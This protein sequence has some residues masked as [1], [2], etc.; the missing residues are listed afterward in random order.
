M[1]TACSNLCCHFVFTFVLYVVVVLCVVCCVFVVCVVFKCVW[2][3]VMLCMLLDV[4]SLFF[5]DWCVMLF[6]V[7]VLLRL[8]VVG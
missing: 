3:Y 4:R 7:I 2:N 5:G 8:F 1:Y 6:V